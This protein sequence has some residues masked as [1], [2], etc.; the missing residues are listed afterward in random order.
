MLLLM[1]LL[2]LL[3]ALQT[4]GQTALR[5]VVVVLAGSTIT[6]NQIAQETTDCDLPGE[7]TVRV[8]P[9]TQEHGGIWTSKAYVC[10]KGVG[11]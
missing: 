4:A 9:K 2:L 1:M 8:K 7:K 6:A 5:H 3:R 11:S 10:G